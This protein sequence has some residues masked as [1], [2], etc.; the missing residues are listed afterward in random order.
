LRV[1]QTEIISPPMKPFFLTTALIA[2]FFASCEKHG[3]RVKVEETRR[4]TVK[5]SDP[6]MFATSN[7]RFLDA[8]PSPIQGTHPETWLVR[9]AR[10]FRLLNY[11][12]GEAGLGE[13]Y[14]SISSGRVL[15]NVNRWLIQFGKDELNQEGFESMERIPIVGVEGVWIEADGEYGAGMGAEAKPGYGLAGVVAEVDGK[16]LTVKMVGPKNE[17]A[18][19]K[20]RLRAFVGSL[21]MTGASTEY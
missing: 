10:Q 9:P 19:E 1:N 13:I 3:D 5:D 4:N 11:S 7:E 18:A 15:E 20:E 21:R 8:K 6:K 17:V 12:F 2:L 14:V 16:I